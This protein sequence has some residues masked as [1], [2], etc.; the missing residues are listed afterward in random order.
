MTDKPVPV[1]TQ[2]PGNLNGTLAGVAATIA[3][4]ILSKAGYITTIAVAIGQPEASVSIL[5]MALIGGLVNYGVTHFSAIKKLNDIY[6][7]IPQIYAEYPK[8]TNDPVSPA[9]QSGN[10][11]NIGPTGT[12]G[13]SS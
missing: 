12:R 7:E 5:A 2:V 4:G 8:N 11:T 10:V 3:V 6:A 13:K 9:P 1:P